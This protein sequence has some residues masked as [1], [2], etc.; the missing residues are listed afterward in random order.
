MPC[1]SLLY[2]LFI[3]TT[4]PPI[5][6]G[7]SGKKG[8]AFLIRDVVVFCA[9]CIICILTAFCGLFV[10][11]LH[12]VVTCFPAFLCIFAFLSLYLF[13]RAF[14]FIFIY[15]SQKRLDKRQRQWRRQCLP[16]GEAP[17]GVKGV[18]VT[19]G[20]ISVSSPRHLSVSRSTTHGLKST[21]LTLTFPFTFCA[22]PCSIAH[23]LPLPFYSL[24]PTH[25]HCCSHPTLAIWDIYCIH[26][27]LAFYLAFWYLCLL[28]HLCLFTCPLVLD[29]L[30]TVWP[31]PLLFDYC[32]VCPCPLPPC[33]FTHTFITFAL[34][35]FWD[36]RDTLCTHGRVCSCLG[37]SYLWTP[38]LCQLPC[39]APLLQYHPYPCR[40]WDTHPARCLALHATLV[41]Q[42]YL[43]VGSCLACPYFPHLPLVCLVLLWTTFTMPLPFLI[44][45]R[46]TPLPCLPAL[47]TACPPTL[48]ALQR[49][50][51]P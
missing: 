39:P 6:G 43:Q 9:L 18:V 2:L 47:W 19:G 15:L 36:W 27:A 33:L 21:C 10:F 29:T 46:W 3:L 26:C 13:V 51:L 1:S 32:I 5:S 31:C 4:S 41:L 28:P 38:T 44:L 22:L 11:Y 45:G 7:I 24:Y 14:Y 50:I 37:C 23:A 8:H 42:H 34:C 25:T 30:P 40:H 20:L 16:D 12:F 48:P 35:P 49:R 17:P